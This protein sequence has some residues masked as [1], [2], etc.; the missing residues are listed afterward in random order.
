VGLLWFLYSSGL[1]RPVPKRAF[2]DEPHG[3]TTDAE[4]TVRASCSRASRRLAGIPRVREARE[5]RSS[6]SSYFPPIQ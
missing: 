5:G 6:L 3:L 4:D 1:I 2:G